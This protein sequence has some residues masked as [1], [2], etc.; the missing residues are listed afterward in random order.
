MRPLVLVLILPFLPADAPAQGAADAARSFLERRARHDWL[1]MAEF[2]DSAGL[3]AIRAVANRAIEQMTMLARPEVRQ[4]LESARADAPL[5]LLDATTSMVGGGSLLRLT[6][7]GVTDT[8][9]L[10]ALSDRALVARWFEAKDPSYLTSIMMNGMLSGII[11]QAA[12]GDRLR[13]EVDSVMRVPVG[14][15]VV[16]VVEERTTRPTSH[17]IYRMAVGGPTGVLSLRQDAGRW[18]LASLE[19]AEQMD[20]LAK[21]DMAARRDERTR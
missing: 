8:A 15:E 4:Q 2:A 18:Y 5:R 16:G 1:A 13:A 6:F 3:M 10:R 12:D 11:A 19:R 7:A 21:L 14:Y 20:Q 9:T 17:V